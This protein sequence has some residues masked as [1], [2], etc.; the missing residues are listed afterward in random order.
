MKNAYQYLIDIN[1]DIVIIT[2]TYWYC[3]KAICLDRLNIGKHRSKSA[4]IG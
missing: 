4:N 1:Q 3:K 2:D